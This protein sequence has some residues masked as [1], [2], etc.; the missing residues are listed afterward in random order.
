MK[1]V[2]IVSSLALTVMGIAVPAHAEGL[3]G[4]YVGGAVG[5]AALKTEYRDTV[6][7]TGAKNDDSGFAYDLYAGWGTR[8]GGPVY[9]GGEL[10]IGDDVVKTSRVIA[11]G[12]AK[13]DPKLRVTPAVRLGYMLSESSMVFTRVGVQVRDYDVTLPNGQ[14]RSKKFTAPILGIG[15]ERSVTPS[16]SLRGELSAVGKKDETFAYGANGA[17]RLKIEPRERR[18]MLGVS[19]H[20]G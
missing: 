12:T 10:G 18:L 6:A 9:L 19:Y 15:Y 11:G 17:S 16:L 20:F 2:L 7:R 3:T 5:A 8:V 1:R 14:G 13:V 4:A